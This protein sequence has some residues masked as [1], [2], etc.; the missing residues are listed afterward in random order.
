MVVLTVSLTLCISRVP[1]TCP[2]VF[3]SS[4]R[5][6]LCSF[7]REGHGTPAFYVSSWTFCCGA[8]VCFFRPLS[9]SLSVTRVFF[10]PLVVFA[11]SSVFYCLVWFVCLLCLSTSSPF[12]SPLFS[13][14][15]PD[16]IA[17]C[18][19]LALWK[20]IRTFCDYVCP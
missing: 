20:V 4:S 13:R 10:S 5:H 1:A 19:Y 16:A 15:C 12:R 2:D 7:W 14:L 8:F 9:S 3:S 18:V 17:S 6:P 11:I